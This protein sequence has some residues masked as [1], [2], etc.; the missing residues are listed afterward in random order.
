MA[1]PQ[2]KTSDTRLKAQ[3]TRRQVVELRMS[4]ATITQIC[5]RLGIGRATAQRHIEKAMADVQADIAGP[6][7]QVKRMHYARLERLL[8]GAWGNA[9]KGDNQS[10][11]RIIKIL[12]RQAKLLGLDAP[13]KLA[14][15]GDPDAPPIKTESTQALSDADLERIAAG[16]SA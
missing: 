12:E 9:A 7:E 11:D 10:I 13:T 4:G 2:D 15:G 1:K 14:H 8:L 16:G 6:A 3:A 5:E